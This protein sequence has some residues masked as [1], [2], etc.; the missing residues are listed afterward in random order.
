M[1]S[2]PFTPA[3]HPSRF[4]S[5][6]KSSCQARP[7]AARIV[8]GCSFSV[9]N[10]RRRR[11]SSRR[12]VTMRCGTVRRRRGRGAGRNR[13]SHRGPA[14][15]QHDHRSRAASARPRDGRRRTDKLTGTLRSKEPA[16][17][18]ASN[19]AWRPKPRGD[20]LVT[21]C[22]AWISYRSTSVHGFA[23]DAS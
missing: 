5:P 17:R 12:R 13:R 11:P 10:R 18:S 21:L 7:R 14:A 16:R 6:G 22:V 4:R 9:D 20:C 1:A 19:G 3:P 2:P 23:R 15:R 8:S